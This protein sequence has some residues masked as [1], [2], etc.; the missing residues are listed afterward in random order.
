LNTIALL[1]KFGDGYELVDLLWRV[2]E[3]GHAATSET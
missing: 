3:I 1:F 2:Y